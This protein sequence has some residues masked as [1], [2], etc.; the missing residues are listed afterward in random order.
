MELSVVSDDGQIVRLR[1]A[2]SV[3]VDYLQEKPDAMV[4]LLGRD[5]YRRMVMID[6]HDV[7]VLD[8]SGVSWL[9]TCL[10]QFR[11]EGG[12]LVLHSLPPLAHDILKVLNMHL[13]FNIAADERE[14]ET[15]IQ[16]AAS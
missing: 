14:A 2:G 4:D 11:S 5:V 15:L 9:L 8:S 12:T 1:L 3:S 10:K 13:L 16:G 7:E 6:M